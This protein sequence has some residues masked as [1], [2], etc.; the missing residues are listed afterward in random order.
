MKLTDNDLEELDKSESIKIAFKILPWLLVLLLA[1]AI[2]VV[3]ADVAGKLMARM[4]D[5]INGLKQVTATLRSS[6]PDSVWPG[7]CCFCLGSLL[8]FFVSDISFSKR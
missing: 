3:I 7:F 8:R 2:Y 1:A 5:D 6:Q 4:L